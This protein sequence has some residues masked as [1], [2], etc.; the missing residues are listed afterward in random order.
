MPNLGLD[1]LDYF[2]DRSVDIG[3][4]YKHKKYTIDYSLELKE[5]LNIPQRVVFGY[6]F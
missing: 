1:K 4:G 3:I 5:G 2:K 6:K